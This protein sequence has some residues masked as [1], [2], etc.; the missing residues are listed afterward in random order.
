MVAI[1]ITFIVLVAV[2]WYMVLGEIGLLTRTV[3]VAVSTMFITNPTGMT[4]KKSNAENVK[5]L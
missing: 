5:N 3:I 4:T 2:V 1:I